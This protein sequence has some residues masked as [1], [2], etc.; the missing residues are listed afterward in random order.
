M[1][2]PHRN[3]LAVRRT[4]GRVLQNVTQDAESHHEKAGTFGAY[5]RV[6]T[7]REHHPPVVGALARTDQRRH[8]KRSATNPRVR[9]L[10]P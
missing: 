3:F 8:R 7:S 4:A 5:V 1:A 9:A 6:I 10:C 2:Q